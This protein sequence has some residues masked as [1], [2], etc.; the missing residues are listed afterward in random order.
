MKRIDTEGLTRYFKDNSQLAM[1]FGLTAVV[2]AMSAW[3][4]ITALA[5]ARDAKAQTEKAS[6][7]RATATRF[8]QQFL[9][10]S[11]SETDEWS[12]TTAEAGGFGISVDTRLSLAGATSRVAETSG[13]SRVMVR[14]VTTDSVGPARQRSLGDLVFQPASFGLVLDGTGSALS[15][16]RTVLRLPPATDVTGVSLSGE[17]EGLKATFQLAVY[18]SAGGPQD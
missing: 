2:V 17:T 4:S 9:P 8:A 14:F 16:A 18:L 15:A 10:A 5:T 13:L 3:I 11:S 1:V 7:I 12:R 6:A